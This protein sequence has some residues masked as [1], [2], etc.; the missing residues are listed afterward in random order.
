LPWLSHDSRPVL[1]LRHYEIPITLIVAPSRKP[2]P[3]LADIRPTQTAEGASK[4][5]T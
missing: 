4:C 1:A 2:I 3:L 5:W